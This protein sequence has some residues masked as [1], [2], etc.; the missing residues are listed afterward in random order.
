MIKITIPGELVDLNSYIKIERGNKFH[1]GKIKKSETDRVIKEIWIQRI[2]EIPKEMYPVHITYVW[3]TK[4]LRK[5]TDN[6]GFS[7]KFLN[8]G[9]VKAGVIENDSRKFI[10]G[11]EDIFFI[12]SIKPRVEMYIVALSTRNPQYKLHEKVV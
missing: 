10:G 8:D 4:D 1:A 6:T 9:L 12:D 11:F 7:K 5:D 3:H 2:K